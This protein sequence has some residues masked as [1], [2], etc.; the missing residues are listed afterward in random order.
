MNFKNL[1]HIQCSQGEVT[2]LV[3]YFNEVHAY[4]QF[5][6]NK[7]AKICTHGC[8]S[9]KACRKDNKKGQGGWKAF[10]T[11]GLAKVKLQSKD[12]HHKHIEMQDYMKPLKCFIKK[13]LR[14]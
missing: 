9:G 14:T 1:R 3:Y 10:Q 4:V 2:I 5:G 6:R 11:P 7:D 13:T 8:S 12:K